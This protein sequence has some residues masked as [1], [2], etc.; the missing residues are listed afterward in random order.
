ML[1]RIGN[2]FCEK[3]EPLLKILSD[4]CHSLYFLI[5]NTHFNFFCLHV[6][7]VRNSLKGG[8]QIQT[9]AASA[10]MLLVLKSQAE[11]ASQDFGSELIFFIWLQYYEG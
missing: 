3:A 7:S 5:F 4:K 8:S 2:F 10:G 6:S 1:L 11:K 9:R